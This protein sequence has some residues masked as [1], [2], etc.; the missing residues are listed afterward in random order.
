MQ[1]KKILSSNTIAKSGGFGQGKLSCANLLLKL[2]L[3]F[4][5]LWE[6]R[7]CYKLTHA[8]IDFS[9]HT[10][11]INRETLVSL[12]QKKRLRGLLARADRTV[13]ER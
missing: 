5:F 11:D 10:T 13:R 8:V 12:G 7:G 2:N 1:E 3:F 4:L 6:I 9:K